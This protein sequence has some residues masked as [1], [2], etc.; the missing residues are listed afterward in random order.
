LLTF[1]SAF[2]LDS[3]VAFAAYAWRVAADQP[4]E[5]GPDIVLRFGELALFPANVS[6]VTSM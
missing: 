5:N 3:P 1:A 6:F 4:P 2:T